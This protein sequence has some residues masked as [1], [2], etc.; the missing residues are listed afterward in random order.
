MYNSAIPIIKTSI[1]LLYR[2]IF[3]QRWL[4]WTLVGLGAFIIAYSVALV[5]AD[6]FQCTPVDSLWGA[7]PKKYCINFPL[8]I[9]ISGVINILT[10]VAILAV[11]VMPLWSLKLS[12]ARRRLLLLMFLIGGM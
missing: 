6:I 2:R 12:A 10:D 3:P 7:S 8:L 1:L 5:I 11:P 4:K 9:K